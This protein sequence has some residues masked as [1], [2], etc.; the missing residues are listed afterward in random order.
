MIANVATMIIRLRNKLKKTTET[1]RVVLLSRIGPGDFTMISDMIDLLTLGVTDNTI[2]LLV[3]WE[4]T[5]IFLL[6]LDKVDLITEELYMLDELESICTEVKID[7]DGDIDG[8]Q[9]KFARK[10]TNNIQFYE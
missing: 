10:Q 8:E 7:F 3:Y 6:L 4:E 1:I 9:G 5:A 2:I